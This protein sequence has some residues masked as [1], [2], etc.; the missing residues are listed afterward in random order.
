MFACEKCIGGGLSSEEKKRKGITSDGKRMCEPCLRM[1]MQY[2]HGRPTVVHYTDGRIVFQG[3]CATG[4][5]CRT[6]WGGGF[7]LHHSKD[8]L[9]DFLKKNLER[10]PHCC[11][12]FPHNCFWKMISRWKKRN[13]QKSSRRH[14]YHES[15]GGGPRSLRL[16]R[17][18]MHSV[19]S[20][21]SKVRVH[22]ERHTT[23]DVCAAS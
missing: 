3:F 2:P 8:R 13:P 19:P 20:R 10:C 16:R 6:T 23:E 14:Y 15:G 18:A 11:M 22:T 1:N 9:C 7:F 12:S 21:K 5:S 4:G 17:E